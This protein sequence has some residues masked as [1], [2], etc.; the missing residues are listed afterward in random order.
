M[1]QRALSLIAALL[2]GLSSLACEEV[3]SREDRRALMAVDREF[4]ER[5]EQQGFRALEDFYDEDAVYMPSFAPTVEGREKILES[6]RPYYD[7]TTMKLTWTPSRAE[8]SRSRDLG[9]TIGTYVFTRIDDKGN[10]IVR[11]GRYITI[12]KKQ[13]DG[14]WKAVL[15]G[16]NPDEN[17]PRPDNAEAEQGSS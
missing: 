1:P 5:V 9:W 7:S 2:I 3:E 12:W 17:T 11:P 15:D 6:Y 8:V 14:T 13:R 10:T 4:A 16:G